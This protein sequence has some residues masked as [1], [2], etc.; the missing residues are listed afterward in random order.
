MKGSPPA[1]PFTSPS[2]RTIISCGA[3]RITR[4]KCE[5]YTDPETNLFYRFMVDLIGMLPIEDQ[6]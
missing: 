4:E 5:Y 6:L 2:T 1:A 3:L